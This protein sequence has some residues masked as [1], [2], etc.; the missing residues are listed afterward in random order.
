M[1]KG[2]KINASGAVFSYQV[3]LLNESDRGSIFF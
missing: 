2:S 1:E 3:E